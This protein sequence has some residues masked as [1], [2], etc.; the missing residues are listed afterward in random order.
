M[1]NK[2]KRYKNTVHKNPF[3]ED[4]PKKPFPWRTLTVI[5]LFIA[6][7]ILASVLI[8]EMF[9]APIKLKSSDK[10]VLDNRNGVV[11]TVAPYCYQPAMVAKSK[12]VYAKYDDGTG[13]KDLYEIVGVDPSVMIT[14]AEDGLYD[15]YYNVENELPT[16]SELDVVGAYICEVE[17]RAG[18]VGSLKEDDAKRAARLMCE[19]EKV[20]Y[21][22]GKVNTES[23][24]YIYF[25]S[26]NYSYLYYYIIYFETTDGERYLGDRSLSEYVKIGDELSDVLYYEK[27]EAK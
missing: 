16:L 23:I 24:S 25:A 19:N 22:A 4:R 11:Y 26:E 3:R 20:D 15:V 6:V 18:A 21:P 14:T 9:F 27:S 17:L 2:R 13:L 7:V 5:G 10:F 12:G 8:F 1:A